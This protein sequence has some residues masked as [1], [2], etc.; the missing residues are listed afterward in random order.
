VLR[1]LWLVFA[2]GCVGGVL[3][4]AV[5]RAWSTPG[6]GIPWSTLVVNVAGAF[7][8]GVVVVVATQRRS[9]ALRL[10]LGTGFCGAL[11]TFSSV[12]VASDHLFAHGHAGTGVAYLA[13]TTAA[14]LAAAGGGLMLARTATSGW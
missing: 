14:A 8:L 7:V 12:V 3:R 9:R 13:L 1:R 4:Y 2:G 10:L 5:T 6:D 11:T